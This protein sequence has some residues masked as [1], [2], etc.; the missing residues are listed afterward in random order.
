MGNFGKDYILSYVHIQLRY[1]MHSVIQVVYYIYHSST[2]LQDVT[3]ILLYHATSLPCSSVDIVIVVGRGM[4][5][6]PLHPLYYI[7][8]LS[9]HYYYDESYVCGLVVV[10]TNCRSEISSLY[11]FDGFHLQSLQLDDRCHRCYCVCPSCLTQMI[12]QYNHVS[13]IVVV[14]FVM[15]IRQQRVDDNEVD[16]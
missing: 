14:M 4:S 6:L 8:I 2:Y 1:A 12:N 9:L 3:P 11:I 5:S 15:L 7:L 10:L 13:I 16:V